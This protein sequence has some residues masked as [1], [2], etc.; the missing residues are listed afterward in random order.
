MSARNAANNRLPLTNGT[1]NNPVEFL[2]LPRAESQERPVTSRYSLGLAHGF[3]NRQML[4]ANTPQTGPR[5][6][7][8]N[9]VSG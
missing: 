7:L 3:A 1:F 6:S 5:Y 8:E 2:G 4:Q 9:G